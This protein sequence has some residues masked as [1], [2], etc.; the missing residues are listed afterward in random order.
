LLEVVLQQDGVAETPQLSTATS[1]VNV[2]A[3]INGS[4]LRG[5]GVEDEQVRQASHS[6]GTG[7]VDIDGTQAHHIID[8]LEDVGM[9]FKGAREEDVNRIMELEKRDRSELVAWEQR[10]LAQ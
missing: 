3:G 6:S 8:I 10:Q 1:P 7:R 2:A 9:H 4:S 5:Q